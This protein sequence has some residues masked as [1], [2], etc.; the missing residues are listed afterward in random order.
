MANTI[1]L[2]YRATD[3]TVFESYLQYLDYREILTM[4]KFNSLKEI[5]SLRGWA[6]F[7]GSEISEK[8]DFYWISLKKPEDVKNLNEYFCL[9]RFDEIDENFEGIVCVEEDK[10]GKTFLHYL[11]DMQ[12]YALQIM[13]KIKEAV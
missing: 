1:N 2:M 5:K 4:K 10:E 13:K 3:G 6:P 9:S 11:K 8:N 7:D 12:G